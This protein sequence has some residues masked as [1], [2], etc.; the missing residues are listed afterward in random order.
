MKRR[1]AAAAL[2]CACRARER[3]RWGWARVGEKGRRAWPGSWAAVVDG[4]EGEGEQARPA[5]HVNKSR[6]WAATGREGKKAG[7][8]D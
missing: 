7:W 3:N 4:P 2:L 1:T 5:D 8:A 6:R